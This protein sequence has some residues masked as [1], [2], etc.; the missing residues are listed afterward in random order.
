MR[1]MLRYLLRMRGCLNC[2]IHS[3]QKILN[4]LLHCGSNIGC[5]C[6]HC[7]GSLICDK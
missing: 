2:Q 7:V 6:Y 3:C 4:E 1:K 5:S